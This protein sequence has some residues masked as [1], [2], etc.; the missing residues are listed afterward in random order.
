MININNK[1]FLNKTRKLDSNK[2]SLIQ[3]YWNTNKY[4]NFTANDVRLHL[5]NEIGDGWSISLSSVTRCLKNSI[6]LSYKKVNKIHPKILKWENKRKM[7]EAALLQQKLNEEK[8]TVIYV[9]EFKFSWHSSAH[10]GW[11]LKGRSGY[12]GV[13]PG[14][15]QATFMVAFSKTKIQGIIATTHTFNSNIFRYF[16]HQLSST[17]SEDYALIWDNSKIHTAKIVQDFAIER[18]LTII[19]IPAYWPF[20]NAWEK[21]ILIIKSK[22]RRI[23]REGKEIFC[24]LSRK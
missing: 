2:V 24:P 19:T 8:V 21:L 18:K 17:L 16:L 22:V 5:Q 12:R 15:F 7:L 14:K 6:G 13:T 10:Y 9:D 1:R 11:S 20:V 23:E 4:D 3:N